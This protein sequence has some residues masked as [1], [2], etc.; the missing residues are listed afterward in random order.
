[1]YETKIKKQNQHGKWDM[2]ASR[3]VK[4]IYQYSASTEERHYF[5]EPQCQIE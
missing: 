1:M 5:R 4:H 2:G 3:K